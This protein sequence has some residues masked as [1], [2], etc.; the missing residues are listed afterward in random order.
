MSQHNDKKEL[1]FELD[2]LPVISMMSV[3]ICFL[4]LTA[5]WTK[6]GSLD[7]QQG[8]GQ[9]STRTNQSA[10]SLWIMM[11]AS[12]EVEFSLK[13]A[14]EA[15][16]AV[17]DRKFSGGANANWQQMDE[18]AAAMKQAVPGLKTAL[19]MPDAKVNYGTVIKMMDRLKMRD[20][21]EV[22][23]APL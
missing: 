6:L 19:I 7:I 4:L 10:P 9:E 23:I 17:R 15:P 1:N 8:L 2:L 13:D 18:A 3:C 20:I 14:L 11:K 12:G 21:T 22:G 16:V 5:V